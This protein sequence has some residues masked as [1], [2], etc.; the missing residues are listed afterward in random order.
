MQHRLLSGTYE[1]SLDNRF[2]LAIPAR[3][4]EPFAEG[5]TVVWWLDECLIVV[6]RLEF[7]EFV[8]RIF[9]TMS[10]LDD[11]SRELSRFILA[12]AF[13]QDLDRQGRILLPPNLREH[14]AL[15]GKVSVVGAGDYL[16]LW[17]PARL[18]GRFAELQREGVSARAKRLAERHA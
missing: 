4:R 12:G 6:P 18:A 5:A 8:E 15:D 9:G 14:A 17:D 16:E 10:V 3:V 11:D 7:P 13:H 2:R 1:C